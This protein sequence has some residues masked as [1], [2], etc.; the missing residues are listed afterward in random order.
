MPNTPPENST[1]KEV[2]LAQFDS[3]VEQYE[4]VEI[5]EKPPIP[6]LP[7][8]HVSLITVS[9]VNEALKEKFSSSQNISQT[10]N[11]IY[12]AAVTVCLLMNL[13]FKKKHEQEQS[14]VRNQNIPPWKMRL[15]KKITDMRRHIGIL[16]HYFRQNCQVSGNV[17]TKVKNI[18]SEAGLQT[19]KPNFLQKLKVYLETLRQK[20]AAC[21]YKIRKYNKRVKKYKQ[22]KLFSR[23]QK[24]FYQSITKDNFPEN[25]RP[26][27]ALSLFTFWNQIW[28]DE[29]QHNPNASWITNEEMRMKDVNQM[30]TTKITTEDVQN[31]VKYTQNWKSPGPDQI[32]NFWYKYFTNC[33]SVLARQFEEC[34]EHPELLPP[35]FTEGVTYMIPK[36]KDVENPASLNRL[37]AFQ[38]FIRC[39]RQS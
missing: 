27:S 37:H 7:Y 23:H 30:Q 10:H 25:A 16:T 20:V 17:K 5:N 4:N 19:W 9:Q 29:T 21:G 24:K 11:F 31:A 14:A 18:A 36:N 12:C 8:G 13:K 15:E 6:I 39:S 3:I 38:P 2:I 34:L 22:N 32:Q 28:G 33:H 35:K 1:E 26:P